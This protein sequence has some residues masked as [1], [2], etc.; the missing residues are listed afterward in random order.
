MRNVEHKNPADRTDDPDRMDDVDRIDTVDRQE[1]LTTEPVVA[2]PRDAEPLPAGPYPT[3][4][5][6][7][8]PLPV[9]ESGLETGGNGRTDHDPRPDHTTDLVTDDVKDDATV[10]DTDD[11]TVHAADDDTVHDADDDT[12]HAETH[13]EARDT[14]VF[15]GEAVTR[16][17]ARW[18]EL[19][20]DFVDDPQR[21]VR[22]ADDVL[23]EVL[24]TITEHRERLAGEWQDHTDT[25]D[26]RLAMQ[27][28]RAFFDRLLPT[29]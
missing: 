26:L 19:Q 21:A 27:G 6:P 25:E 4:P 22:D 24:R 20:A 12:V 13:A 17:R 2:G 9:D 5:G 8:E 18:R 23:D 28:Y 1:T 7:A 11:D 16:L 29:S 10:H 3:E 14:E 15:T